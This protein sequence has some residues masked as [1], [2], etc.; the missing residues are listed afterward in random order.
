MDG[1]VKKVNLILA[2]GLTHC[3]FREFLLETQAEL[4]YLTYF[5]DFQ[6]LGCGK[7][8]PRAYALREE[9]AMFLESRNEEVSHFRDP[10][11]VSG[12]GFLLDIT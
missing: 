6:W 2:P 5:W 11:W 7:M 10:L 1:I 9:I 8:V 3:Q 12:L 4:G